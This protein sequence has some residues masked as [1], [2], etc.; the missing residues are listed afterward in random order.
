LLLGA[1]QSQAGNIDRPITRP[2]GAAAAGLPLWARK[3]RPPSAQQQRRRSPQHGAQRHV[4]AVSR[5]HA[6]ASD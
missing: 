3:R 5:Y 2:P 1:P 4:R 6:I